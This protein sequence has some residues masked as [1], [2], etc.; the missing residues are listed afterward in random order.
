MKRGDKRHPPI[1]SDDSIDHKKSRKGDKGEAT[2]TEEDL[3]FN[4]MG[5]GC[6]GHHDNMNST[7]C[8]VPNI[9]DNVIL[10]D[11]S[12]AEEVQQDNMLVDSKGNSLEERNSMGSTDISNK[13]N[14]S[15][16]LSENSIVIKNILDNGDLRSDTRAGARILRSQ[17]ISRSNSNKSARNA[18]K[19][20][21]K[22]KA[23]M[24]NS[25]EE[26]K[27]NMVK[28]S[29]NSHVLS[30]KM[31]AGSTAGKGGGGRP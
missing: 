5:S 6:S 27:E 17:S 7:E 14:D 21:D 23:K 28:E 16:V 30:K 29:G 4:S 3:S 24:R 25:M 10:N 20:A 18:K 2:V 31:S 22:K 26:N 1:D 19:K 13:S 9:L 11:I 8:E 15:T 12:I